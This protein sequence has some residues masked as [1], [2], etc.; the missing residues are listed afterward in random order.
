[1]ITKDR[2]PGTSVLWTSNLN[3]PERKKEFQELMAISNGPVWKRLLEI[4][5]EE[6]LKTLRTSLKTSNYD[7]PAW[8]YQQADNV[9]Y[10]RALDLME[11]LIKSI[12]R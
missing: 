10:Q 3:T 9:G 11:H 7:S 6:K 4:V 1:M 8:A 5:R 2:E 12:V